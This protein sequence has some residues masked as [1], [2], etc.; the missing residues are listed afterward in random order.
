MKQRDLFLMSDAALRDVIDML[1]RDQLALAAPQEWTQLPN[2]TLRTIVGR[3]A[4]D[5]A[6][7]PDVLAG[8]TADDVGDRWDGDLLGD[9]PVGSYD[10]LNDIA[11]ETV[12]GDLDPEK[13][14][15]FIYGDY[16]LA[17]GLV[18][19]SI[20]RAFQAWSIAHFVGLDFQLPEALVDLLEDQVLPMVAELRGY[21]V[22]PPEIPAP[23]GADRETRLL[24]KVGFWQN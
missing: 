5:E 13:T 11:T 1:D 10:E 19:L 24:C 21:G 20:Y 2:P 15:H 14:V 18:H 3:H 12:M 6:W 7:I 9:D 23:D 4:Y 22:F 8:R 16:P 17:E